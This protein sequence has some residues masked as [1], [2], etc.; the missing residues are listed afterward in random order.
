[1]HSQRQPTSRIERVSNI[2]KTIANPRQ[3]D[4]IFFD[5]DKVLLY[6]SHDRGD[7]RTQVTEATLAA[8]I[9]FLRQVGVRVVGLTARSH[10][11]AE[12]TLEQLKES[13]I[14]LDE[15]LHAPNIYRENDGVIPTKGSVAKQYIEQNAKSRKPVKRVFAFDD[16]LANLQDIETAL[17]PL[18]IPCHCKHYVRTQYKSIYGNEHLDPCFPPNLDDY[19][20]GAALGGGSNSVFVLSHKINSHRLVIKLGTHQEAGKLEILCHALYQVMGVK[21]PKMR[22]YHTLPEAMAN[23]LHLQ[24][25]Y[26]MLWKPL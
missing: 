13:G 20:V 26:G 15:V 8:D 16:I 5:I 17:E 23:K 19:E 25:P 7:E 11:R 2:S 12:S 10:W 24:K 6:T 21:V 22:V 9:H 4:L 1:M 14:V 3:G 18:Q